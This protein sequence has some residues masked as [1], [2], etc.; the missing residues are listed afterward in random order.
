M[1]RRIWFGAVLP[2]RVSALEVTDYGI[3]PSHV[4][5]LRSEVVIAWTGLGSCR[6]R[7]LADRDLVARRLQGGFDFG[8][9]VIRHALVDLEGSA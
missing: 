9:H 7:R 1:S 6:G 3:V 5:G 4:I 8:G 2:C